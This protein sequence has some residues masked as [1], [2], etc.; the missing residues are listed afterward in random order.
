MGGAIE[1]MIR[2]QEIQ[3]YTIRLQTGALLP[4]VFESRF[5]AEQ[6]MLVL[7]AEQRAIAEIISITQDGKQVLFG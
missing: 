7:P 1:P 5:L 6:H 2:E 3:K 4:V